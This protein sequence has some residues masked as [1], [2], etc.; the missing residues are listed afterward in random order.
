MLDFCFPGGDRARV[1]GRIATP[2]GKRIHAGL[3]FDAATS[4]AEMPS[5]ASP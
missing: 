2:A 3:P 5:S 1:T 4:A